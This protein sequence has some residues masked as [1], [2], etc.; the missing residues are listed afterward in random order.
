MGF[1]G[2]NLNRDGAEIAGFLKYFAIFS[3]FPLL[4][5]VSSDPALLYT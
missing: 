2:L 5:R 3:P 4:S 1:D